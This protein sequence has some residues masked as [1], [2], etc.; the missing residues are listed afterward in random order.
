MRFLLL[1]LTLLASGCATAVY[2]PEKNAQ[3][4]QADIDACKR[5]ANDRYYWDRMAALKHANE[6]LAAKGYR[7]SG[8]GEAKPDPTSA[9]SSHG[10][11]R[12][13]PG[14]PCEIPC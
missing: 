7:K 6:C 11:H 10:R 3:E 4:T 5:E 9:D 1:P 14:E 12:R 8:A 13:S 2:N